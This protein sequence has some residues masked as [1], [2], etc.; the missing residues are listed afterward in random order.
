MTENIRGIGTE[1]EK[2]Q[3]NWRA[4][5]EP[6]PHPHSILYNGLDKD[7]SFLSRYRGAMMLYMNLELHNENTQ[8]ALCALFSVLHK[9]PCV[10]D[11]SKLVV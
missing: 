6:R 9:L 5:Q 1:D 7:I 2:K 4:N 10:D 8:S 11:V 3:H